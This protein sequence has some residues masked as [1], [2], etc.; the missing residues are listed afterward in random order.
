MAGILK[1]SGVD[2]AD[3]FA[4]NISNFQ[5][6]NFELA[7]AKKLST[8]LDG[9]RYIIDTSRNGNG[10]GKSRGNA[11][12]WSDPIGVKIGYKPTTLVT[13][14]GLD[15]FLWVKPPGEADGSAFPAGSW[16]PELIQ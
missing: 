11:P 8:L 2:L 7:Y 10:P 14:E 6:T 4:T 12:Q 13:H 16:H 15:A 1:G 5:K 3:G 9:K